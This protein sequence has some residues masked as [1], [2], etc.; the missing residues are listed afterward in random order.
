MNYEQN[1]ADLIS[2]IICRDSASSRGITAAR[3]LINHFGSVQELALATTQELKSAGK[4]TDKQA[5]ALACA[6]ELGRE[7]CSNPF[8]PGEKFSCSRE[9]FQRYKARF[10][11]A[12]REH[13]FSLELNSKNQL[14]R[15]VL[16]SVGSLNVSIVHPRE[17]FSF[18]VKDSAS[19]L[20]LLHNHPSGNP[21]PSREDRE[22]TK[23]LISAGNIMG[24]KVLDHIV[25]GHD[26]Y[27]SFAD[28]SQMEEP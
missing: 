25:I 28:A 7:V 26:D 27:Y 13:F 22:C 16:I 10:F 5:E 18:A 21:T 4:I 8:R 6:L 12:R 3:R 14:I 1:P 19:A 15:E 2:G 24:I 20:I 17:I 23:R 9:L 11:S